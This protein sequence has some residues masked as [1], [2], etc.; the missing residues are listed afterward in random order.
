MIKK[1][2]NPSMGWVLFLICALILPVS[3]GCGRNDNVASTDRV[4]IVQHDTEELPDS[5]NHVRYATLD[6]DG[7]RTYLPSTFLLSG[8]HRL[9]GFP[10]NA[11][12]IVTEFHTENWE[13]LYE[14]VQPIPMTTGTHLMSAQYSGAQFMPKR[15]AIVDMDG[16]T[17]NI[18]VRGNLPLV[19]KTMDECYPGED[20]CFAYG[21]INAKM[22]ERMR[23]INPDAPEFD[24]ENY[25]VIELV[26][27]DGAGN[28]P[29]L[30]IE[31]K[32][33]GRNVTNIACGATWLPYQN[34]PEWDPETMYAATDATKKLW[35]LIWWPMYP[36]GSKPCDDTIIKVDNSTET[37]IALD[38]FK[39]SQAPAH[40]KTLL[41][42][43]STTAKKKLIYFHCIQ[44]ADR[45]G[46]LHL[47]Y[48]MDQNPGI[49]FAD[50]L[51][52]VWK[53]KRQGSEVA[54]LDYLHDDVKP[55]C[56]FVGTAW[57][58]CQENFTPERCGTLNDFNKLNCKP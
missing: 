11:V 27:H 23:D 32:A 47:A 36:C 51:D 54:Q 19:K 58:Y 28:R 57:R 42:T 4:V 53:G 7:N 56:K 17:G 8:S 49:T 34:C 13:E 45:T 9:T 18:L 21:E 52:R 46:S 3:I 35:G 26:L 14:D 50:A 31:M 38:K 43:H 37:Q 44:G 1:F 29:E 16:A 2:L 10:S 24:L 12:A 48:I 33:L 6:A 30:D 22:K 15:L 41:T 55:M 25:D 39:F 20:R 5:V 40:L